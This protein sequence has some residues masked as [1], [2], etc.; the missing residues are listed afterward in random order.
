[1]LNKLKVSISVFI[2][3]VISSPVFADAVSESGGNGT[4]PPTLQDGIVVIEKVFNIF[5]P[6]GGLLATAMIVYGGYMWMISTGD[7]SKV[8]QAQ[9]TLTWAV[10]GLI[11]LAVFNLILKIV[12]EFLGA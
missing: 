2:L 6:I 8:K 5:I 7:P 1:M 11:F 12:F 9:G 3:S 10:F 4:T